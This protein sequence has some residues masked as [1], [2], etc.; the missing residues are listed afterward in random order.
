MSEVQSTATRS[1]RLNLKAKPN[2]GQSSFFMSQLKAR[3]GNLTLVMI[4][5]YFFSFE[6]TN[7]LN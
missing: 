4:T 7:P 5:A 3:G 2:R 6:L 1:V